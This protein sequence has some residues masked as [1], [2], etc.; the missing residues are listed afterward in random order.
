MNGK[1]KCRVTWLLGAAQVALLAAGCAGQQ[2]ATAGAGVTV[3]PIERA[4]WDREPEPGLFRITFDA[5]RAQAIRRAA[6]RGGTLQDVGAY[7]AENWAI[8]D[9]ADRELRA[10]GLCSGNAR[11]LRLLEDGGAQ[12]AMSGIFKCRQSVF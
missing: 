10:R 6:G 2:P 4:A 12:S 11:L 3:V 7:N 1:R 5:E 9:E 8:E